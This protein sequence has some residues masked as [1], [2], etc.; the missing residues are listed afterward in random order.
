MDSF[1]TET[2]FMALMTSGEKYSWR[3]SI[4]LILDV[5]R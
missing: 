5:E 3:I 2:L 1:K 4:L